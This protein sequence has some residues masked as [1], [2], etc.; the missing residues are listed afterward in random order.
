MNDSNV[1]RLNASDDYSQLWTRT[2]MATKFIADNNFKFDFLFKGDDDTLV[3]VTNLRLFLM[4]FDH[5][6]KLFFGFPLSS[7]GLIWMSGGAGYIMT[8]KSFNLFQSKFE[9]SKSTIVAE[10]FATSLAMA[11]IGAVFIAT[12]DENGNFLQS[13]LNVSQSENPPKWFDKLARGVKYGDGE[14]REPVCCGEKFISSHYVALSQLT[15][16]Q[17]NK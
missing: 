14:I 9:S 15:N 2:K 4:D 11:E 3:N 5:Q 10:D 6:E 8:R 12:T 16:K 17:T 7:K 1:I 13:P